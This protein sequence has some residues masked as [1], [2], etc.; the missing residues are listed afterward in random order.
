KG[1]AGMYQ[2]AVA[3]RIHHLERYPRHEA[4]A[5]DAGLLGGHAHP[6]GAPTHQVAV[7]E[8]PVRARIDAAAHIEP[9]DD[10][11]AVEARRIIG[12]VDDQAG[13][14]G[15]GRRTRCLPAPLLPAL[16][17]EAVAARPALEEPLLPHIPGGA[18]IEIADRQKWRA[19][20]GT[21]Q[22]RAG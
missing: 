14:E 20:N 8:V 11:G 13:L 7:Q 9:L 17:A 1:I 4:T 12:T 16:A 19:R 22:A 6:S 15:G 21:F 10:R 5:I 18:Q 2:G 3:L